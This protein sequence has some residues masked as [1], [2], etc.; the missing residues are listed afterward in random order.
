[1]KQA[2]KFG[3]M[4]ILEVNFRNP[5]SDPSGIPDSSLPSIT[6]ELILK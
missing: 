5:N 4:Q 2:Y 1:M 6:T 3:Y